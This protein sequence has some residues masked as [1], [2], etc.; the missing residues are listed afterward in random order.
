MRI[1][2]LGASSGVA[3]FLL[4]LGT[5]CG[6]GSGSG[7]Y[8]DGGYGATTSG[9]AGGGG[10]VGGSSSGGVGAAGG[11]AGAAGGGGSGGDVPCPNG[12]TRC[13]GVCVNLGNDPLH[14]GSCTTACALGELC[15]GAVCVPGPDCT[16][17][18][19]TGLTYCDLATGVCK[20]GC[21]SAAQCAANETCELSTHACEC[22][23]GFTRYPSGVCGNGC[24]IGG[25]EYAAGTKNPANACQICVPAQNNAG[26]SAVADSTACGA[27]LYCYGGTCTACLTGSACTPANPC[28]DGVQQCTAGSASC[29]DTGASKPNGTGCGAGKVCTSGNCQTG[30]F[31][32][33]AFYASG[34]ASPASSCQTCQPSASV[35]SFTALSNGTSCGSG[36]V[37]NAGTCATGCFIGGAFYTSGQASP[38]D[39]CKA[40]VPT[41]STTTWTPVSAGTSCGTGKI[42]NPTGS[43]VAGC[44]IGGSFKADGALDPSNGCR[45][46]I[47]SKST[48]AYSN[49]DGAQCGSESVC[50]QGTCKVGCWCP[51]Q[52]TTP[53]VLSPG[54]T[55]NYGCAV[56]DP[57][58]QGVCWSPN[59]Y[60]GKCWF[61]SGCCGYCGGTTCNFSG[62]GSG[63]C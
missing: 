20:P 22:V 5:G 31:V 43:C 29:A 37:C 15:E 6:S 46:C 50:F 34:A 19:C 47:P 26:W 62:C 59:P 44:W 23:P 55:G 49:D 61:P 4:A 2:T 18:P 45:A 11:S 10:A 56:C 38:S 35:T 13:D 40:C 17:T 58:N 60:G 42:C 33:G 3:I 21:A 27:N 63:Y 24:E 1:R 48:T 53:T 52:F 7:G 16:Q 51:T 14:C 9:G 32:G 28:H 12:D 30:C 39:P 36:K 8:F 25:V 41:T 57:S 54:Q